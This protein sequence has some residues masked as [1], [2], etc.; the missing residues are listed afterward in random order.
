MKKTQFASIEEI[1]ASYKNGEMV[2]LIDDENRENEGDLLAPASLISAEQINFMAKHARGLICLTLT[3]QRC[4]HL[5]LPLMVRSENDQGGT[6]FTVSI[7]AKKGVSTGISAEDRA[8]TIKVATDINTTSEDIACPGHI[9]PVRARDGGVLVRAGH[10][11][12]GC[13]LSRL[14]GMPVEASVIVEIMKEDGQMARV[15]DLQK[16]SEQHN[17]KLGTIES[18]IRYRLENECLMEKVDERQYQLPNGSLYQL[19]TYWDR[20]DHLHHYALV[21]GDL[22]DKAEDKTIWVRVHLKN[23]LNDILGCINSPQENN[24]NKSWRLDEAVNF[25]SQ[26]EVPGVVVILNKKPQIKDKNQ[27]QSI[28]EQYHFDDKNYGKGAQILNLLGVKKIAV[29]GSISSYSGIR[30]FG[31]EVSNFFTKEEYQKKS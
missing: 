21:F 29:L 17:I 13:D 2:I 9:F 1:I 22:N 15:E 14:A 27:K 3:E 10:T 23:Y 12:A 11:E 28:Q 5:K 31:I 8:T 25:M 26:K 4:E 6:N 24:E 19:I 16:F 7:E 20:V 18:L 30:G